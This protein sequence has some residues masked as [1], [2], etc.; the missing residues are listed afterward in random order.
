MPFTTNHALLET[1]NCALE[2]VAD[3]TPVQRLVREGI[4]FLMEHEA[5]FDACVSPDN[6]FREDFFK[7]L[8]AGETSHDA[9]FAL[10]EC[11]TIFFRE[12]RLRLG[13]LRLTSVER[14]VLR[15]FETTPEWTSD[16]NSLVSTWYWRQLPRRI[17]DDVR[18]LAEGEEFSGN[19]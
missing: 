2:T 19:F 12:K 9:C 6:P 7:N 11:V 1:F 14:E 15:Y 10:F 3:P 17:M 4:R 5:V 8:S 18:R 16:L 13:H